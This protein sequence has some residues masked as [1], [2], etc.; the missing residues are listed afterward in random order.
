[1]DDNL[2]DF[3]YKLLPAIYHKRDAEQDYLLQAFLQLISREAGIIKDDIRRLYEN[4]FIETCDD[5]IISYIGDLVGTSPLYDNTQ[6]NRVD[7]AKTI[8]YR[9]RKGTLPMLEELADDITGWNAHAVTFFELLLWNQNLNHQRYQVTEKISLTPDPPLDPCAIDNSG[10]PCAL[11]NIGT[12]NLRNMNALDL[13]NGPFDK[14][15]HTVD[16]RAI[17]QNEGWFN[18]RN[19]GFFLWRL[20]SYPLTNVEARIRNNYEGLFHFSPLGNPIPLFKKH[21]PETDPTD[22]TKEINIQGPIRPMDLCFKPKDYYN[23]TKSIY[24]AIYDGQNIVPIDAYELICKN[25][26][27]WERPSAGKIAVDVKLGRIAFPIN[28]FN[29]N[30]K[31]MVSYHYGFSSE[32]GGGEY[33]RLSTLKVPDD[34]DYYVI[35]SKKEPDS[36]HPIWK[37][38]PAPIWKPTINDA[39]SAWPSDKSTAIITV[40]DNSTYQESLQIDLSTDKKLILQA[41]NK[42]RPIIRPIASILII[43]T[44]S[45]N[46]RKITLNGFVLEGGINVEQ[47][48]LEYLEINHCTIIPGGKLD[49]DGKP[50]DETL[51]SITV[52]DNEHLEVK[53][54][55]SIT[56][57]LKIPETIEG[58]VI[59]D[60]IIDAMVYQVPSDPIRY[61]ISSSD[62]EIPIPY[63]PSAHIERSTIIGRVS[64]KEILLASEVIF[65]H[66]VQVKQLQEGCMRFSYVTADSITPRQFKCQPN[67][68]Y[69]ESEDE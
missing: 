13:L 43:K 67:L 3:F 9:R 32:L 48:S 31:L 40:I 14:I 60:S 56:G 46:K 41:G 47:D 29:S 64:I 54:D 55:K 16:V 23:E 39:I 51:K 24:M 4:F 1:M 21:I 15:S 22:V 65:T 66:Q 8:Y 18:I 33:D 34:Q 62:T 19:I 38:I 28:E 25:L 58:I 2:E 44:S 57:P 59:Q 49:E 37:E 52:E 42:Y 5:W 36:E 61:A 45:G 7:V 17:S 63:G 50:D 10:D 26:D 20:K 27:N 30:H 35:V 69:L 53:I 12:V 68:A 6:S 11:D